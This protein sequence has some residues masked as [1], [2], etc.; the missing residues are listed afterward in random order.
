MT[1][2]VESIDLS[3][4]VGGGDTGGLVEGFLLGLE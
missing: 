2:L 3:R 1:S 4:G